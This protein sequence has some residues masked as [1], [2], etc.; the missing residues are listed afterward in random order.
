VP[1]GSPAYVTPFDHPANR[2]AIDVLADISGKTPWLSRLGGTV[3]VLN[4]FQ[5]LL[6]VTTIF[7]GFGRDDEHLHAPDEF[8]RLENFD[9]GTLATTLLYDRLG[10]LDP[11]GLRVTA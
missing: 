5:R 3:P 8:L 7:F 11:G 1:G 10:A 9:R 6:G 4:H 2:I